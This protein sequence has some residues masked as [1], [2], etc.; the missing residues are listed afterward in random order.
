M[1][2]SVASLAVLT[3]VASC[4]LALFLSWDAFSEPRLWNCLGLV[5]G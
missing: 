4:S 3:F 1:Q 5:D 2:R